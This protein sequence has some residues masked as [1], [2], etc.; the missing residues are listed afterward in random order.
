MKIY[1]EM[2]KHQLNQ[3]IEVGLAQLANGEKIDGEESYNKLK[4]KV[5]TSAKWRK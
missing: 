4:E 5:K 2:Q 3:A 1:K